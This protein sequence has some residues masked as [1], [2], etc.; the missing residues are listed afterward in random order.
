MKKY[1]GDKSF[2]KKVILIALPIM[3]QQGITQFVSLLDNVMI[4]NFSDTAMAGVSVV[5]QIIFVFNFV[6]IG[7]LAAVGIYIAQYFGAN[8]QHNQMLCFRLKFWVGLIILL[9]MI[10]IILIFGDYLINA[11]LTNPS[12]QEEKL[13]IET[14]AKDYLFIISFTFL[15]YTISQIYSSTL[16]EVGE[17]VKPMIAGAI[18]VVVNG[19]FNMWFIYGGLGLPAMG[20]SGAAI[21][22]LIARIVEMLFLIFFTHKHHKKFNF[23]EGV[24]KSVYVP[25]RIIKNVLIKGTPLI[26]NEL[27]WSLGTTLLLR[28]YSNRGTDILKAFSISSTTTNL[29]Y[30][31]FGAMA[32]AISIMV[33]QSL[34]A[35][36]LEEAVDNDRKLIM[37]SVIVC[38]IFGIILACIAPIIPM[39]YKDTSQDV[40]KLATSLMFVIAGCMIIFSFNTSCFYTLRAGGVTFV[41]FL[42][43][44]LFVWVVSLPL[45]LVLVKLTDASIV[46]VYFVV[47]ITEIIKSVIGYLL[48][49]SKI[50][51]KNLVVE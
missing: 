43:D 46:L 13:A 7:A 33:G 25:K 31:I 28:I 1:F 19:I 47:Q 38:F 23:V 27:L 29:F 50:W 16:R 5:N 41:T 30:I 34:G 4:G 6:I 44:S 32:S 49:K 12:S 8:D 39:L 9:L 37:F 14:S 35:G 2:Y 18:A 10:L 21:A 20:A 15:P 51:V 48:I 42:F 26:F 36:N 24:F 40:R 17:T 3:L 22:T 45:A 11:F